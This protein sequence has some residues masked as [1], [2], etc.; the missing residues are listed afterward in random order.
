M[1][2]DILT[3]PGTGVVVGWFACTCTG[4]A[5]DVIRKRAAE[6]RRKPWEDPTNR[7]EL[8]LWHATWISPS[9]SDTFYTW[10][11]E[12][13]FVEREPWD[14]VRNILRWFDRPDQVRRDF[15]EMLGEPGS[16]L[17]SRM[18]AYRVREY[19]IWSA[20]DYL[21]KATEQHQEAARKALDNARESAAR[22]KEAE[23]ER[24]ERIRDHKVA[25]FKRKA[26]WAD[27]DKC[28]VCAGFRQG[29]SVDRCAACWS[30]MHNAYSTRRTSFLPGLPE[31]Y[32]KRVPTDGDLDITLEMDQV[33]DTPTPQIKYAPQRYALTSDDYYGDIEAIAWGDP[34]PMY[35]RNVHEVG[36]VLD[37]DRD[38][39]TSLKR[40]AAKI[41]RDA[42]ATEDPEMRMRLYQRYMELLEEIEEES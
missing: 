24:A 11:D 20:L 5:L 21:D 32:T 34:E 12:R 42:K 40:R 29:F 33:T 38:H 9:I 3:H 7:D 19:G 23:R 18:L 37:K 8:E 35:L 31:Y 22:A 10:D 15:S 16:G 14:V 6:K 39:V 17:W 13:G 4:H 1:V 28:R 26:A 36:S 25:E 30:E 27:S 2:L 41:V